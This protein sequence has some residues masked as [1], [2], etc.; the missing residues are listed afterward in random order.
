MQGQCAL[1]IN[2]FGPLHIAATIGF[3]NKKQFVLVSNHCKTI[4]YIIGF[5]SV[6]IISMM[7]HGPINNTCKHFLFPCT[8]LDIPNRN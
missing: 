3:K 6:I 5:K 2:H 1:Y 8:A 4:P 7:K